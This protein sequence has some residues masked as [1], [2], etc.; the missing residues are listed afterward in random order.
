[1]SKLP[2]EIVEAILDYGDVET[3]QKYQA[4]VIQL[5]Y[6]RN[7]FDYQRC[8]HRSSAWYGRPAH[9]FVKYILQ[10]N[11]DKLRLDQTR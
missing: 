9:K 5:R 11:R 1:M 8:T 7:E 6:H 3:T 4:V 10:K 2:Y